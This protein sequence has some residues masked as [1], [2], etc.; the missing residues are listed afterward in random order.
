M[1]NK[2][3]GTLLLAAMASS[4]MAD[5]ITVIS[6][7]GVSKDVQSEAFYKPFEKAT[8]N[9]VI[10]GEYNGEMGRIKVMVD[11]NSV[12]WDIVQVEA[13]EL[14]R[15]CEEGM[16]EQLDMAHLGKEEDFVPGTLSDCGAGLLIWSMA[17]AYNSEKLSAAPTGWNDFWDTQKFPG[18]RSLRK[19]AK[20]TL[21]IALMADGVDYS[22]I[23]TVLGTKEGVDRAF[24]K[25]DQ[26]KSSIQWWEAGAQPMQ[27]LA[28]GDVVMSTAFNGRVFSAQESGAPVQIVWK[29]SI[30]AIDSW[31]I[32][33]GSKNKAVAEQFIE[34]SLRPE[35]QK[36]HTVKLGYGSTNLHTASLLDPAM[37]T[38]LNSA[39][40]NLAQAIP[41][42]NEFWV[43]HGEELEQ[44]FNA[45]VAKTN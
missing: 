40:A 22:D 27:F 17:M 36:I 6:F 25:L 35:N 41:M 2:A 44:R 21:E 20:Y 14:I 19:G 24:N 30:Y 5:E 11:T 23:Y 28:S 7:G 16:F 31:A 8:G 34:F 38:R 13:P 33:K 26:I 32:P 43:D 37:A 1:K 42:N 18:K 3:I 29:G 4:S 10:A 9:K 45:W 39:P 12:N 15:G